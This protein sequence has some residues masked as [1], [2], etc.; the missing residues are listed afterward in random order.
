[1]YS[2]LIHLR[3]KWK[4]DIERLLNSPSKNFFR[5]SRFYWNRMFTNGPNYCQNV[6]KTKCPWMS[7]GPFSIL[8]D[9]KSKT[10]DIGGKNVLEI[11][12]DCIFSNGC[13]APW[14]QWAKCDPGWAHLVYWS[15]KYTNVYWQLKTVTHMQSASA[16][17]HVY[18][19]VLILRCVAAIQRLYWQSIYLS[20]NTATPPRETFEQTLCQIWKIRGVGIW[21]QTAW[22]YICLTFTLAWNAILAIIVQNRKHLCQKYHM[23]LC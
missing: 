12:I 5:E 9:W 23:S 7:G 1:M 11:A 14:G 17:T 2:E 18:T 6:P 21:N 19:C 15:K 16:C 22:F 10:T 13:G 3:A 4:E 20:T 8:I